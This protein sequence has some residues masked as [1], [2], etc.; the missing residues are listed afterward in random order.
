M[1]APGPGPLDPSPTT[2]T[3]ADQPLSTLRGPS[4][5]Q[6]NVRRIGQILGLGGLLTL[7]VLVVVFALAG[8]HRND[9]ITNLRT[10]GVTVEMKVSGCLIQIGGTGSNPAGYKCQGTVTVD[11]HRYTEPIPGLTHYTRGQTLHVVVVP[12]DPVLLSTV[13]DLSREHTSASVYILPII[14]FVALVLLLVGLVLGR[15]R[16]SADR[17]PKA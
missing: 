3:P 12:N 14:L 8:A 5:G 1:T 6:V 11:G 10:H 17:P 13:Q 2:G 9:Q 15:R 16:H 4:V 7:A